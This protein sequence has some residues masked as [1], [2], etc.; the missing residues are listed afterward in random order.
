[1][2]LII[3][4][5]DGRKETIEVKGTDKIDKIKSIFADK[6]GIKKEQIRFIRKGIHLLDD[7]T[8]DSSKLV[9]GDQIHMIM[10]LKGGSLL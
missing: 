10:Q 2:K 1:M 3:K 8:V 6:V 4:K 7:E 9:D 5:L